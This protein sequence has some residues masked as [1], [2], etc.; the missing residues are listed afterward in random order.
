M[1]LFS[2]IFV[3]LI[4]TA[5]FLFVPKI[6]GK[7]EFAYWQLYIFYSTYVN[8]ANLGW[9]DGLHLKHGGQELESLNKSSISG[10]YKVYLLFQT[11]ITVLMLVGTA[12][13]RG[14]VDKKAVLLLTFVFLFVSNVRQFILLL[15][16]T[17]NKIKEYATLLIMAKAVSAVLIIVFFAFGIKDYRIVIATDIVGVV[18]SLIIPLVRHRSLFLGRFRADH[19]LKTEIL[20]NIRIGIKVILAHYASVVIIGVVRF[21][22][23][24]SWDVD[25]FGEVSLMLSLSGLMMVFIQ[26]ISIVI[27]PMLKAEKNVQYG[28]LYSQIQPLTMQ[29]LL[30]LLIFY[31]PIYW[32]MVAWLPQFAESMKYLVFVFPLFVFEGKK[33]LLTNTF[34]KANRNEKDIMYANVTAVGVG[35]V[36]TVIFTV[37]Y[38]NLMMVVLS[39]PLLTAL[40]T[41]MSELFLA[42][43]IGIRL[44][45]GIVLELMVC[46]LFVVLVIFLEQW[47][48]FVCLILLLALST[49][50]NR[51]ELKASWTYF[52]AVVKA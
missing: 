40:S 11:F 17:T 22:I 5:I 24:R 32:F 13:Y 45:K 23:E 16:Q 4:Q 39:I 20:D 7:T 30:L 1:S 37:I 44:A 51:K 18:I 49:L 46:A 33:A 38:P 43:R 26:A 10:Q 12:F 35:I 41:Y 19:E 50:L 31:Y 52:R 9:P 28:K 8:L 48:S 34:L 2:N 3:L 36:L 15:F 29:T 42:K 25:T 21:G 27:F 47:I 14:D 6:I